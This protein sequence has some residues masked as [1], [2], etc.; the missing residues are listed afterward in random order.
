VIIMK[1]ERPKQQEVSDWYIQTA[2]KAQ[3]FDYGP[4]RG[5]IV[6]RP[7]GYAIW[8]L[9]QQILDPMIKSLGCQNV[10]F[11][12]LIPE[13]LLSKE[14]EHVEGFSPECAVVTYA[15]GEKLEEPLIVRPTSETIMY[16]LFAKWITSWRDL[17][18]RINQW[19]NVVRWELRPFPFLRTIEFLWHEA[20]TAH[21]TK[22]ESDQQVLEALHM[23]KRFFE[24]TLA[25]PV[26]IGKKTEREK[27]AGALYST[28]CEALLIDGKGLQIATAHNLG[29]NFSKPFNIT[30]QDVDG[31]RKYVWQTSWGVSTRVIGGLILTHGDKKGLIF[32]PKIAPIQT[33]IIPIWKTN[34]EYKAV[35]EMCNQIL[36]QLKSSGIRAELDISDHT[37][38]WKFNEW[39]LKGVPVRIEIGP[40]EVKES[41]SILA[42]RD[43]GEKRVVSSKELISKVKELFAEIQKDLFQRAVDFVKANTSEA[44][45]FNEFVEIL[46]NKRG[47]IKAPWCGDSECERL[48][49]EKTKATTRCIPFDADEAR[50]NCIYC[51]RPAK[52]IPIWARAH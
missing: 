3:L 51:G 14:K 47:F 31:E 49:K 5:T 8:E 39:E 32:P 13:S 27:F 25:I 11:P 7:Y 19:C 46:E 24:E 16:S 10:Y 33:I 29:Q 15:G 23:Y 30:F 43:S 22:E 50:G 9:I 37:P 38:G 21:R 6:I 36:S 34:D 52:F 28:S 48:I 12:S 17:P 20:H 41:K 26:V 4:A 44:K 35:I 1:I 45:N 18:L 40:K 2:K 42:R